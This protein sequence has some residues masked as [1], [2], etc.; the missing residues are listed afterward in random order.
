MHERTMRHVIRGDLGMK[1][2]AVVTKNRIT[3][4]QK[5][6]R[7]ERSRKIL[8]WI[9]KPENAKKV[10]IFSDEKLFCV[11]PVLNRRNS[12]YISAER[13]ENVPS[14]VKFSPA[15]KM[16]Q[17]IMMLGVIS[18]DGKKCPPIFINSNEKINAERYCQLLRDHVIP[19]IKATYKK[20][21]FVFQQD[22]APAHAAKTTQQL[23]AEEL[24]SFWPK[25]MWPPSSPDLS[26]LDY[27]IWVR[28]ES[29]ACATG[30]PN[31]NSLQAAVATQ[32]AALPK[33]YIQAVC[34]SFRQ[35]LEKV[36]KA[37]GD[38]IE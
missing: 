30:H 7:V 10:R 23:L 17:K 22:G 1:S 14:S 8:N 33:D 4:V 31:L 16:P 37:G 5:G 24:G 18:S 11:D 19:W 25:D 27:S 6:T 9:K 29:K 34:S 2:R 13:V 15:T 38:Y 36:V 35:R 21:T 26:P 28:V 3:E 20:G 32:W 12:R